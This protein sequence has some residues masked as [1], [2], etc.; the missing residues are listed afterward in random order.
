M[1]LSKP[2]SFGG[3]RMPCTYGGM[4]LYNTPTTVAIDTGQQYHA[5]GVFATSTEMFGVTFGASGTGAIADT[6]NNGGVLRCTDVGHGLATGDYV[7]LHGMGDAAHVGTTRV[8]WVDVDTFDCDDIAYNSID[9]TGNW[10][11]GDSLTIDAGSEGIYLISW[12]ASVSSPDAA[13]KIFKLEVCKNTTDLDEF[14]AEQKIAIQNDLGSLG[15]S[16]IVTLAAGDKVWLK[17][18]NTEVDTSDISFK[19][20]TLHISRIC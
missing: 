11:R 9:D 3:G 19:H 16:G 20:V 12:A 17:V 15:A 14:V 7:C 5:V 4:F 10:S 1:S 18:K 2:L 8:T 13:N 6:A